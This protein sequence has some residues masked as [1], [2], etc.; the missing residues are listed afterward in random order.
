MQQQGE[1]GGGVEHGV[2]D[3]T[4]PST[5]RLFRETW[6]PPKRQPHGPGPAGSPKTLR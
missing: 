1:D 3:R 5:T 2:V 6:C 4:R